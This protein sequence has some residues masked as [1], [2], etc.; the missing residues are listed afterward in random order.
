MFFRFASIASLV[1]IVLALGG[2]A[3]A[4]FT[5]D[6]NN[7]PSADN[8]NLVD[9]SAVITVYGSTQQQVNGHNVNVVFDQADH[10][11]DASH[12]AAGITAS[13][14]HEHFSTLTATFEAGYGVTD[15][16]FK[17]QP[18]SAVIGTD[19]VIVTA[20]DQ[21]G[22]SVTSAHLPFLTKSGENDFS[23]HGINGELI[24]KIEWT[25]TAAIN[26]QKQFS[27]VGV[28]T[29]PEP[30]SIALMG[31]GGLGAWVLRRRRSLPSAS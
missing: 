22:G 21:F 9:A 18:D 29:V 1:S 16:D 4:D 10:L 26:S 8:I 31:V 23:V 7:I 6:T 24:T 3:R 27:V 15:L 28:R 20:Y 30:G 14:S 19:Y 17:L 25:S 5:F 12:G 13:G 11:L 2:Q